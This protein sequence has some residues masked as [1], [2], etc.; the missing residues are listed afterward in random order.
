MGSGGVKSAKGGI[1]TRTARTPVKPSP[2][3]AAQTAAAIKPAVTKAVTF[4]AMTPA[5]Q[6]AHLNLQRSLMTAGSRKAIADYID[7]TVRATNGFNFAQNLNNAMQTGRALTGKQS[8]AKTELQKI[9]V[10]SQGNFILYRGDHD[11]AI[12]TLAGV[13]NM[14]Q[15][16]SYQSRATNQQLQQALVGRSWTAKGF[17][18]TSHTKGL[19]PFLPGGSASGGREV[20]MI[21]HAKQGTKMALIQKSQGEVLLDANTKFTITKASYTGSTAYPRHG[22]MK[23]QIMIEVTAE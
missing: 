5:D 13:Q 23:R 12:K 20:I 3:A 16:N 4:A 19:S 9:M 14:S 15:Y 22:G 2:P 10:P 1:R 6:T 8:N 11:D 18:S 21:I 7:P 17:T